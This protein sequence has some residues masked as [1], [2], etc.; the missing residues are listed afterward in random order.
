MG[1]MKGTHNVR[2]PSISKHTEAGER[3]SSLEQH[4]LLFP[5]QYIE[6]VPLLLNLQSL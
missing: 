4:H 1:A 3:N 5:T 2:A 6:L